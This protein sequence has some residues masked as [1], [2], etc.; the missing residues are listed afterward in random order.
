MD[1]NIKD[2]RDGLDIF[3]LSIAT[4]EL[5]L[6]TLN[7]FMKD[8]LIKNQVWILHVMNKE[9]LQ[10]EILQKNIAEILDIIFRDKAYAEFQDYFSKIIFKEPDILLENSRILSLSANVLIRLLKNAVFL[11][12][13]LKVVCY[14]VI[15][16]K[17]S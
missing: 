5:G 6:I 15:R 8:F 2:G 11:D 12:F 10:K 17:C 13:F 4:D 7:E 16:K 9:T 3:E 14:K 1:L